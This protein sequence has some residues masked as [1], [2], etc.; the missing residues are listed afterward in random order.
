MS[1]K[2]DD[3]LSDESVFFTG[4]VSSI[5]SNLGK[6][7]AAIALSVACLVTFTDVAIRGSF[8]DSYFSTLA[9]MIVSAYIIY[10]SLLDVGEKKGEES[11][12]YKAA[13]ARYMGTRVKISG[14]M[15]PELR[16]F[17]EDYSRRELESRKRNL[18]IC[19]GLSP[20]D[21]PNVGRPRSLREAWIFMRV[22][23]MRIFPL[24]ARTLLSFDRK[25][26]SRELYDPEHG[27]FLRSFIK[28]L[29]S[30]VCMCVTVSVVLSV[31]DGMSAAD[32][33]NGILKL[34]AL[35]I[36]GIRGYIAGIVFSSKAKPTWLETKARILESF[37][38]T[39]ENGLG[40]PS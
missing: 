31:K 1:T 23:R 37:F 15:I 33:I 22:K 35:P 29:P 3:L 2:L 6:A 13:K 40:T 17:C 14:E 20:E 12:E 4:G 5:I 11:E 25:E 9:V 24:T 18:L 10:F 34:C 8:S 16:L 7:V 39:R 27:K 38:K 19:Y 26:T 36:I 21:L 32:V 28:L 30:V